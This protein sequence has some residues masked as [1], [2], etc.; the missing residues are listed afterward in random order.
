M[1]ERGFKTNRL[2]NRNSAEAKTKEIK[3]PSRQRTRTSRSTS[4]PP[5][6]EVGDGSIPDTSP[7]MTLLS[8]PEP[9]PV[10][11]RETR[12][13][14]AA[15]ER[16]ERRG[17]APGFELDDWL[18]AEREVDAAIAAETSSETFIRDLSTTEH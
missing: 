5:V 7:D 9:V 2:A 1:A 18:A 3:M 13:A 14:A 10:P 4:L 16:A 17:F 15:Y 6:A 12:I 11:S 8:E